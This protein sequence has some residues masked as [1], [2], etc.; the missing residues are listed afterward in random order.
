[1]KKYEPVIGLEI[2]IQ[3]KTKSKMFSSVSAD[4]FGKAPNTC[5]DP[6]TLGLPGALPVPNKKAIEHCVKLSLGLSCKINKETKFDRKNYFYPDLPK[7]Y[8]IS[9]YDEPIGYEG[10]LEV[11]LAGGGKSK[12][13]ITRVH[14]EEDTGKSIH[15]K[16]KT[17][18]DFNKAGVPLIE[19]V[20][21][22]DFKTAEEIDY[23]A[24]R[25]RQIVRYLGVSDADMEKGQMRYELN[26]SL[27]EKGTKGLPGY[28]VEVKNIGS[29]SLLQKVMETEIDRQTKLLDKGET[30]KQETRGT[31]DMSGKTYSQRSKETSKDYR[32]FP[33]PDI[34]PI[35]FE[36]EYLSELESEMPKLPG[37]LL[38]EYV[39][40]LGLALEMAETIV[41]EKEKSDF[42]NTFIKKTDD[43]KVV[44]EIAKLIIGE[45]T[46]IQEELNK[47]W[48]DLISKPDVLIE[49]VK[50]YLGGKINSNVMK[51]V[52]REVVKDEFKSAGDL[53]KYLDKQNLTM[54][55]DSGEL[56][57]IAKEAIEKEPDAVER[58]KK[59]PKIA[60]HFV[61]Q[62]MK[63]T[64]GSADPQK[65]KEIVEKILDDKIS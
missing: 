14:M 10:H 43:A 13:G 50:V 32:Y 51:D 40:K 9:Q 29:I 12:I 47:A 45:L 24:K 28:K 6:V 48:S 38:E 1:M 41:S 49:L 53:T 58:Y 61:G 62:V 31:R 4:Y 8:Q 44:E 22:P 27:K 60:M 18:L 16:D 26:I 2:H 35:E 7:G 25:L 55:D 39:E 20:T 19:V 65:T 5:V 37:E 30:P 11:L 56:E 3:A 52:L 59:N 33:E 42:L 54:T 21:E 57:E 34:P 15:E 36:D 64:K 23:F 17:L 46:V 63:A